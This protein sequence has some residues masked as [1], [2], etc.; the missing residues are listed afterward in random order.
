MKLNELLTIVDSQVMLEIQDT[1]EKFETKA[2]V[3]DKYK[4]CEVM[5][6]EAIG[7]GLRFKLE[8]AKKVPTLEELGYSFEVGV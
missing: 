2:E 1:I 5:R 6:V 7:N 3:P 8:K 4:N